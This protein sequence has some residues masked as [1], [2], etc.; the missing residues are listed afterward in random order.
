M[1]KPFMMMSPLIPGS[2]SP[3]KDIDVYIQPF[4]EELKQLWLM[5]VKVYDAASYRTLQMHAALI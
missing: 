1:K 5:G 4:V 3:G 2:S